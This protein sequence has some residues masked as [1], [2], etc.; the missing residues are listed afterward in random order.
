MF[1][2][3]LCGSIKT[4]ES[5]WCP[6]GWKRG[7][8]MQISYRW[9]KNADIIWEEWGLARWLLSK[10]RHIAGWED[11]G[12]GKSNLV[13]AVVTS[14]YR[15]QPLVLSD[16]LFNLYFASVVSVKWYPASFHFPHHYSVLS[17]FVYAFRSFR[18][19]YLWTAYYNI[20]P[21]LNWVFWLTVFFQ[22]VD[23]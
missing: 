12:W 18:F 3:G 19:P 4:F 16:P 20:L 23:M 15:L 21:F 1:F 14:P 11:L 13:F 17:I 6:T 22:Y 5:F 2:R 10:S 9:T 7:V 8:N